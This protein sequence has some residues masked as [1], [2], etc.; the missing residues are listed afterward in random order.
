MKS[1][2]TVT[3]RKAT[4]NDA[5]AL[6]NIYE[7]YVRETAI[8]FEYDVPSLEEFRSRIV[9]TLERYPYLVA[10]IDG[11]VA[12]YAYTGQ[13]KDRAAYDWS[14]ETSIYIDRSRQRCGIGRKLYEALEKISAMQNVLNMNACIA[15]PD[16]EDD[17]LPLDSVKFHENMGY[18]LVGEFHDCGCKFGRWYSMVW[19]E[20]LIGEHKSNPPAF[21]PF[22]ELDLSQF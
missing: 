5:A 17:R 21:I 2:S 14:V 19:M 3:I 8:T 10:E 18:T 11:A 12:G 16:N 20:K 6:L 9:H 15:F 4:A 13:F 22:P 7:V 1:D